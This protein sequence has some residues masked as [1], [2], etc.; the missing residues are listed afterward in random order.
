MQLL[1]SQVPASAS[2]SLALMTP[3]L[4]VLACI[5]F[6]TPT[7]HCQ[8]GLE[9][10][11]SDSLSCKHLQVDH[12]Q[13]H[14]REEADHVHGVTDTRSFMVE[15]NCVAQRINYLAESCKRGRTNMAA[16]LRESSPLNDASH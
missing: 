2:H 1:G 3:H 15:R 8:L 6:Q 12:H 14:S 16:D 5:V 11:C 10:N 4:L 9:G 13:Y 7:Q